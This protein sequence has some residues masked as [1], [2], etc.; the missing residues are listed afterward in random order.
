MSWYK[1][2]LPVP[3]VFHPTVFIY[4]VQNL[5]WFKNALRR[6]LGNR[7]EIVQS[8]GTNVMDKNTNSIWLLK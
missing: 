7:Y 8:M 1:H 3:I 6:T 4:F 2:G 5:S